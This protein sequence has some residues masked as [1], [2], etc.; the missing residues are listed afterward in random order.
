MLSPDLTNSHSQV[1]D[2]GPD[3]PLVNNTI[4]YKMASLREFRF[5]DI[6]IQGLHCYSFKQIV[7]PRL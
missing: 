6:N 4:L 3:G 1:S 5:R 7:C 2:P